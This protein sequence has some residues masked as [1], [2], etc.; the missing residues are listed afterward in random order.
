MKTR[1]L[2]WAFVVVDVACAASPASRFVECES[3]RDL[4][5]W[6]V[7]P[8]SMR[9]IGSSYVMAHG[10]GK[11]VRDAVTAATFSAA[12]RYAVWARTRN[13]NAVW[14]KG[15]AGRFQVV[16]D[17]MALPTEL[18]THGKDWDWQL[19]GYVELVAGKAVEIRLHDLTG[20][21]GRCDALW[22][23]TESEKPP[24]ELSAL[25]AWKKKLGLFRFRDA[26]ETWDMVVVGGGISG[27]CVAQTAARYKVKTLLLQDRPVLGGCNSSEIRVSAGGAINMGPYPALGNVLR[28][29]MPVHGDYTPLPAKF[30]EDERKEMAFHT[31][32]L[33]TRAVLNQYVYGVE[34]D[35]D[36][37][38]AAVLYRDTRTG[39]EIRVKASLFCDATGDGTIARLAGCAAMY[40]RE[41]SDAYHEPNAPKKADR[42]VMGHSIQWTTRKEA[43]PVAFPDIDWRLPI[44]EE[45]VNYV[46]GG[47]WE[48]EAGQ[49]RD[50]AEETELIRDYGLLAIFSN[51]SFIKNHSRRKAEWNNL[52]FE[53]ISAIGGKRESYRIVGDYVMTQ[54]DL[55]GQRK[56]DDGTA[57]ITWDIDL[58]FP[59]PK[60]EK[61]PISSSRDA[62]SAVRTSRSRR[63]ACRRRWACSAR[64]WA[65]RPASVRKSP[66]CRARSTRTTWRS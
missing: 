29:I 22:F 41:G 26:R 20:F 30:Y 44:T 10:Y 38:I 17:G 6:V 36:G 27:I 60:N 23:T 61:L 66:V 25:R 49:Y 11:P 45:T 54:L 15:A 47:S 37:R 50:M 5:G 7:D 12:G 43:R 8:H 59:D 14:T 48:Q 31:H 58:H 64:W 33:P 62:T 2:F 32:G 24:N 40:G 35:A 18:G 53:W 52:A 57:V 4:G 28:E 3:F 9:Q 19:A 63:C 13:W 1:V 21:N 56:F 46:R 39:E 34:K 42:Q 65:W 51:W 16:V 55:E